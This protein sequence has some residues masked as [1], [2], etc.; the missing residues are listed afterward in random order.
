[1]NKDF[2]T[3]FLKGSAAAS[4]GTFASVFCHFLSVMILTRVFSKEAFGIYILILVLV[5]CLKMLAGLGMDLTLVREISGKKENTKSAAFRSILAVRVLAL[6]ILTLLCLTVGG[7]MFPLLHQGLSSYLYLLPP[8]FILTSFRELFYYTLQGLQYFKKYALVQITSALVRVALVAIFAAAGSLDLSLLLF[9]EIF[10]LGASVATALFLLPVRRMLER[11]GPLPWR[12]LLRFSVPLYGNNILTFLYDRINIIMIGIFLSL[13]SIAFFEVARKIPEG[14]ARLFQP[15]IVVYFP[16]L[17]SLFAE[18][19]KNEARLLMNRSLS[20]VALLFSGVFLGSLLFR[21]EIIRLLFSETYREAAPAFAVLMFCFLLRAVS[22]VMG[23]SLV[24]AGHSSVPVKINSVSSVVNLGG[25]ILLI[26]VFGFIG[27]AYALLL[28]VVVSTA[29][30]SF[31]LSRAGLPPA[32]GQV[33][34]PIAC[35]LAIAAG[36]EWITPGH[37]WIRLAGLML[38]A[39]GCWKLMP[40]FREAAEYLLRLVQDR[41]PGCKKQW[42]AR[43]ETR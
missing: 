42:T 24:S 36:V 38:F 5:Q 17:A 31:Y 20:L 28:M 35:A 14:V 11:S 12:E 41:F 40:E 29:L 6:G 39:G 15:F 43:T 23:Y 22:N 37:G 30:H 13:E 8:L 21:A 16:N 34:P 32:F 19:R 1:M 10:S 4:A 33:L 25:S 7:W 18:D 3:R 27:A 9:I 2:L 26:P